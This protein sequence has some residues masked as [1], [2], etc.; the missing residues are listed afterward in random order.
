V[1]VF[2]VKT[3]LELIGK[4]SY[5]QKCG[6]FPGR[7]RARKGNV[8]SGRETIENRIRL[9]NVGNQLQVTCIRGRRGHCSTKKNKKGIRLLVQLVMWYCVKNV[10]CHSINLKR[11][12][13]LLLV[14]REL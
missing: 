3:Q 6:Y 9:T 5:R 12:K 14:E 8:P 13:C 7:S 2:I 11:T 4:Y 10:F 1:L